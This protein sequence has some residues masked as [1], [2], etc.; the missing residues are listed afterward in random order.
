MFLL[1]TRGAL[2]MTDNIP[3]SFSLD[4]PPFRLYTS[5]SIIFDRLVIFARQWVIGMRDLSDASH[6]LHELMVSHNL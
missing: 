5:A 2:G 1:I 6:N 3:S 4:V